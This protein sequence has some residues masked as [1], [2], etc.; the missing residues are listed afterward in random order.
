MIDVKM[1]QENVE[2]GGAAIFDQRIAKRPKSGPC[3]ENENVFAATDL[4]ARRV[5]AIACGVRTGAG[6]AAADPPKTNG[7]G[8]G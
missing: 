3:I 7:Q 6:D 8:G 1:A 4:N 5:A 2:L